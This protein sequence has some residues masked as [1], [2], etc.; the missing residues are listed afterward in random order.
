MAD[1]STKPPERVPKVTA[2]IGQL[3]LRGAGAA[4]RSLRNLHAP[5]KQTTRTSS[6]PFVTPYVGLDTK[7]VQLCESN[8]PLRRRLAHLSMVHADEVDGDPE[9]DLELIGGDGLKD[10]HEDELLALLRKQDAAAS[11]C[12]SHPSIQRSKSALVLPRAVDHDVADAIQ[13]DLVTSVPSVRHES[14]IIFRSP[15]IP[16]LHFKRKRRGSTLSSAQ[17]FRSFLLTPAFRQMHAAA[18]GTIRLDDDTTGEFATSHDDVDTTQKRGLQK[19]FQKLAKPIRESLELSLSSHM[20]TTLEHM[21][22]MYTAARRDFLAGMSVYSKHERHQNHLAKHQAAALMDKRDKLRQD[23]E[24]TTQHL[25]ALARL[26]SPK[27]P[28][29][30]FHV[31][32]P[33]VP[34]F[35]KPVAKRPTKEEQHSPAWKHIK[36]SELCNTTRSLRASVAYAKAIHT[37][38][39]TTTP[40]TCGTTLVLMS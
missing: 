5:K 28:S 33:R 31:T 14:I 32:T 13:H 18:Y 21:T 34:D 29:Q 40:A 26:T 25:A 23:V 16:Y 2:H 37:D 22:A 12:V 15:H 7:I 39:A 17:M 8:V 38:G 20:L 24:R 11:S 27:S 10:P 3:K 30:T 6:K 19:R 4:I 9:D 35:L 1:P 36:D